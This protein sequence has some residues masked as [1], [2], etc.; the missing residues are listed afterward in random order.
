VLHQATISGCA[1][2]L[3]PPNITLKLMQTTLKPEA[4]SSYVINQIST[5][6]PDGSLIDKNVTRLAVEIAL[7]RVKHCFSHI[8]HHAY[9][10]KG[11]T[12][13]SHLH[14]DQYLTF[15]WFL[16]NTVWVTWE[17]KELATKIYYL[18]KSL[19]AFDCM[20]NTTLPDIFFIAHGVGTVL[21]QATYGNYFYASTGCVVGANNGKYPVLGTG[22]GLGAHASVI[23][24]CIVGDFSS[25]GSGT[26]IFQ[27]D[28]PSGSA[29]YR[30]KNGSILVRTTNQSL[31]HNIFI[32]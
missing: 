11:Q 10:D 8:K 5:F 7:E 31:A 29:A 25:I 32:I 17:D 22:V 23:G 15:L 20:Y 4:I 2:N 27:Q 18:N 13:F 19:H 14:S 3:N 24:E 26:Q 1:S 9:S 30:N 21:G 6:F 16:A 12:Y 28:I